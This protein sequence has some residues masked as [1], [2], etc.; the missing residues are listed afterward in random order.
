MDFYLSVSCFGYNIN[1]MREIYEANNMLFF[2]W[3]NG[4][5]QTYDVSNYQNL[6]DK[7]SWAT[8]NLKN[9]SRRVHDNIV[10]YFQASFTL[11]SGQ[12]MSMN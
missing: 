10:L 6:Q 5:D 12:Q 7:N 1:A 4:I 3:M 2:S 8:L 11:N 9:L